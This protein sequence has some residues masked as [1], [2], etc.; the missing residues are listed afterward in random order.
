[1]IKIPRERDMYAQRKYGITKEGHHKE[2]SEGGS[3]T[4]GENE[5][6]EGGDA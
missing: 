2:E 6:G 3:Q 5:E 4:G 1:M